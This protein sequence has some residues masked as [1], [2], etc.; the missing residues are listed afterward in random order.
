MLGLKKTGIN[1]LTLTAANTYS[2]GTAISGGILNVNTDS[3]LGASIGAVEISNA[4]ALQTDGTLSTARTVTL[5]TDGGHF[6]TNGI[7]AVMT[8]SGTSTVTGT[9][10]HEDRRRHA[11]SNGAQT[12]NALTTF[13]GTTNVNSP[14]GTGD[15]DGERE[16]AHQLLRQPDARGTQHRLGPNRR[17]TASPW[18]GQAFAFAEEM[19]AL[20]AEMEPQTAAVPEPGALGLLAFGALGFLARRR[21][22]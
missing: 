14:L 18:P 11:H 7:A 15:I 3:A 8:L 10:P 21:R 4:A 5:G 9:G 13:A 6:D 20:G 1:K 16:R 2:G 17:L 22:A 19:P 12:Y